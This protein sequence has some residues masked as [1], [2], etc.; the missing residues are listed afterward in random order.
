MTEEVQGG[1]RGYEDPWPPVRGDYHVGDPLS[2]VAVVTLTSPMILQG[3]AIFGQCK[4]ENL[5]IEKIVANVISNCNIRFVIVCGL[6]SK[7]HLP[8]NTLLALHKNGIDDQGRIIGSTGAIP[9][10][11]NIPL[12]AICRFQDQVEVIDCI[13]IVDAEEIERLID[14]FCQQSAPYPAEP[15]QVVKRRSVPAHIC[16]GDA[17]MTFGSGVVMDASAWLVMQVAEGG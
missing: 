12:E 1:G 6:E 5:G 10:I 15:F 7:G 13:G 2:A 9:F 14:R 17:D 4:T 8:G 3:S 16:A 11:Q